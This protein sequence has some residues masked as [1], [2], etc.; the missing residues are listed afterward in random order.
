M[1]YLSCN[2]ESAIATCDSYNWSELKSKAIKT[3]RKQPNKRLNVR[4][5][6]Y[7][8]LAAA[9]NGFSAESFLGKGSHGS[10]YRAVLDDGKLVAAVKKTKLPSNSASSFHHHGGGNCTTPAENEIEILSRV[11]HPRLVNLLG[12]CTDDKERKLIVVEYMPNGSLYDLLHSASRPPGWTRRVRFGLQVAKAVYALHASNPPVIHRDIKSSNVLIDQ[13]R[14]A[15]LG[16]FGLA[17][18]GHV[19]D[20]RVKCTPPAGTLGYLDPGYLAP[21][22]LTAKSDVFS[23]GILLLEIIS[24][25]NAID[26]NYSPPSIVD[27]AVPAVKRGDY[28]EIC[29]RRIGPPADPAVIRHLAVLAARC[30]RSTAEKRPSM[31]EV[32]EGLKVVRRRAHAPPIWNNFRQRVRCV[33]NEEPLLCHREVYDGSEVDLV[34]IPSTAAVTVTPQGVSRR[35]RKVS[36]VSGSECKS[37][38]TSDSS[39]SCSSDKGKRVVR[40]KSI[41]SVNEIKVGPESESNIGDSNTVAAVVGGGTRRSGVAVKVV[42]A[43]VRLSKS[44]S[45]GV[46]RSQRVVLQR[47]VFEFE[48]DPRPGPPQGPGPGPARSAKEFDMSKLVH[49]LDDEKSDKKLL[50][51]PLVTGA[52]K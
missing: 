2:G 48:R 22:D 11:Q 18:R 10:V 26:V 32:V 28:A 29:D 1:G 17:L 33:E 37:R 35:N 51:K 36:S 52:V 5:F 23:F 30:V 8:E 31:A 46:S 24:G 25:R 3:R 9:T 16:D 4:E 19:E 50:E 39:K 7:E 40:S 15:R 45:L 44:R 43:V 21:G 6:F 49:G 13:D 47:F 41:G 34:K 12:F 38:S 42:P 27:W 20:V 14:N